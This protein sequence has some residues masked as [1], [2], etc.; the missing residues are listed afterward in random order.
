MKTKDDMKKFR[1]FYWGM[2]KTFNPSKFDPNKWA[3]YAWKAGMRY[4][5]MV[6]SEL[7]DLCFDY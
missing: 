6:S 3:D 5:V 2:S 7:Y 1:E 4:I